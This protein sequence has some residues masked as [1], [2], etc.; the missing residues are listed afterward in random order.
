MRIRYHLKSVSFQ[1][2]KAEFTKW[3]RVIRSVRGNGNGFLI[4]LENRTF[5]FLKIN[6]IPDNNDKIS[7]ISLFSPTLNSGYPESWVSSL[8]KPSASQLRR[9][10]E[11]LTQPY[12]LAVA[13]GL[14]PQ[15]TV[16]RSIF[17]K[18]SVV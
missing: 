8:M 13:K 15:K 7:L 6:N 11:I 2:S 16:P 10:L 18:M 9:V 12:C 17:F 4:D 5:F 14:S 1:F 3:L